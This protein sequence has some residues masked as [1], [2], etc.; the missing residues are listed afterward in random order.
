MIYRY[1]EHRQQS[2]Y[3]LERI[4]NR[5]KPDLRVWKECGYF[6]DAQDRPCVYLQCPGHPILQNHV[7]C[8]NVC[9]DAYP[10]KTQEKIPI[11]SDHIQD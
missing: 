3:Y 4:S 10:N 1:Q 7:Q 9:C 5:I 2:Y 11:R 6:P 8:L